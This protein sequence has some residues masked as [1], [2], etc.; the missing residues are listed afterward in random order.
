MA[1]YAGIDNF[2]SYSAGDLNLQ[3]GGSGWAAEWTGSTAYDVQTSVV[4]SSPNAVSASNTSGVTINRLLSASVDSGDMYVAMRASGTNAQ[5]YGTIVLY[6]TSTVAAVFGFVQNSILRVSS[7]GSNID[8]LNPYIAGT[9]YIFHLVFLSSTTFK[10]RWKEAGGSFSSF[11][12][13]LTYLNSVSVMNKVDISVDKEGSSTVYYFD[14]LQT[15]DPDAPSDISVSDTLTVTESV[16]VQ[17]VHEVN[18][19][20]SFF[21][22]GIKLIDG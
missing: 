4:F 14:S 8:L 6:G 1:A 7:N 10:L 11:T 21:R 3:N 22:V 20:S 5:G 13:T 18:G 12:S 2:D 9:W 17:I 19:P 15:T 16:A